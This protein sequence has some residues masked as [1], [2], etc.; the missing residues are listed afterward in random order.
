MS[1]L[2]ITHTAVITRSS[3]CERRDALATRCA[4]GNRSAMP[5]ARQG[6]GAE[7]GRQACVLLRKVC[8][9]EWCEQ[10]TIIYASGE[11]LT[12]LPFEMACD[13][14]HAP[15]HLVYAPTRPCEFI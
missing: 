9:E 14:L 8:T 15:M 13:V 7:G 10:T 5:C 3:I 11:I 6:V 2:F 1:I 4:E 12:D